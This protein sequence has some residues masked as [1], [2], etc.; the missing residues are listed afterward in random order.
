MV[1][2]ARI[3]LLTNLDSSQPFLHQHD[4]HNDK[5]KTHDLKNISNLG[6]QTKNIYSGIAVIYGSHQLLPP[7]KPRDPEWWNKNKPKGNQKEQCFVE[8]GSLNAKIMGATRETVRV[9]WICE[10]PHRKRTI[11]LVW[12]Q[13]KCTTSKASTT[14]LREEL[15]SLFH[16]RD[17]FTFFWFQKF[18]FEFWTC[19]QRLE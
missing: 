2:Y 18:M 15:F 9:C 14:T 1:K 6:G 11:E 12:Q 16:N 8:R 5:A 3:D 4:E 19:R 10:K 13:I 7:N 17:I